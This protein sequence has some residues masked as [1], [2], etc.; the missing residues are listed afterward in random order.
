MAFLGLIALTVILGITTWQV[1]NSQEKRA[2]LWKEA[3]QKPLQTLFLAV[4]M[5]LIYMF[6]IGVF[7]PSFG[8]KEFFQTGWKV[9]SIGGVGAFMLGAA[10]LFGRRHL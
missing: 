10:A 8:E 5:V 3:C 7:V 6:A 2:E 9:W 4:W 1:L